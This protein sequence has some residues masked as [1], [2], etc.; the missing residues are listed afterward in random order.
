VL[1]V[2]A[3]IRLDTDWVLTV[4]GRRA[5]G[6]AQLAACPC[7]VGCLCQDDCSARVPPTTQREALEKWQSRQHSAVRDSA[8]L[9]P[10]STEGCDTGEAVSS[11]FAL[12]QFDARHRRSECRAVL[13]R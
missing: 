5:A 6:A 9:C 11:A 10:H 8:A 3:G 7:G 1:A 12:V 2:R 13:T 4:Q